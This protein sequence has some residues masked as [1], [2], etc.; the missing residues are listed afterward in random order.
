MTAKRPRHHGI[1]A[2][3]L[4]ALRRA[5]N[6]SSPV[7]GLT[8]AFYR[9]PARFSPTFAGAAIEAFSQ[10]GQFVLDPFMGGGTTIV[11]AVAR[12]RQAI[13]NDLNSLAVFV[14]RVKTTPLNYKERESLVRWADDIIPALSYRSQI[15]APDQVLCA[16]RTRNLSLPMARPIKKIIA[17]ALEEL[18]VLPS[19]RSRDLARCALLNI[20][21]L[22][23]NGR[24][25][26]TPL[27]EFRALL[28]DTIY[29][30]LAGVEDLRVRVSA[31]SEKATRPTLLNVCTADLAQHA[32]FSQGAKADLVV[33][34]PPYPGIHVLY[35]RWQVDGRRETPA[36]YWIAACNDGQGA[37]FYN[38]AD[39]RDAAA[40]LYFEESL[41][42][43]RGLREVVKP[44]TF[45]IQLVAFS[46][47]RQH[48]R[49]YLNNMALAGFQEVKGDTHN[50][51]FRRIWREVPRRRWHANLKGDLNSSREVVLIHRAV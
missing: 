5:A 3:S 39:R 6:D 33:T 21:Q 37:A 23:L 17:L 7:S 35:H 14:T 42:T 13:G 26:P 40:D 44:G 47:P 18:E 28:Q 2:Q 12:G 25:R 15:N 1:A 11:E 36:P 43:L 22:A 30:M 8:H 49:R 24:R 45:V 32:P 48:L 46:A 34:S 50:R 38:F 20:G 41:R 27:S 31:D 29:R 16:R 9:Y 10:P 19:A 4:A 51:P